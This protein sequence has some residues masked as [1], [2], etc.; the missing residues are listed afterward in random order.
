MQT[1]IFGLFS[2]IA[3]FFLI[4]IFLAFNLPSWLVVEDEITRGDVVVVLGGGGGSRLRK[5][6]TLY[7]QGL[8]DQI[9]LVDKSRKDWQHVLDHLC[10]DCRI[11]GKNVA[12]LEGSQTTI[13]DAQLVAEFTD[14]QSD[15]IS[16]ILVVT[17]PYHTRRSL[18]VFKDRFR[19]S[20]IEVSLVSSANFNGL[21]SPEDNWWSDDSTLQAIMDE[22]SKILIFKL[23]QI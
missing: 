23:R 4:L 8:A 9:I 13:T 3:L 1:F 18:M 21:L 22:A 12:F 19:N 2:G 17:D 20:G 15:K 5:G 16:N 14:A 10:Q 11:E 7:D 6:I